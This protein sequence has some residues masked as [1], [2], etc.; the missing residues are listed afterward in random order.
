[1]LLTGVTAMN[2]YDYRIQVWEGASSTDIGKTARLI[3]QACQSSDV[4][5]VLARTLQ[6]L[7]DQG[8]ETTGLQYEI[9]EFGAVSAAKGWHTNLYRGVL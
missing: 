3:D 6:Q 7:H 8:I 1:M 4:L 9:H 5:L 2:K